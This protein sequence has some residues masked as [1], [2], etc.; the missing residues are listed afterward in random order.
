MASKDRIFIFGLKDMQQI[1]Q[2]KAPNHL[3]RISLS[4]NF[5]DSSMFGSENKQS[6]NAFI[7]FS[8][9]LQR[10]RLKFIDINQPAKLCSL[11]QMVSPNEKQDST[12]GSNSNIAILS[13]ESKREKGIIDVNKNFAVKQLKFNIQGSLLA[14]VESQINQIKIISAPSGEKIC[15]L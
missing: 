14:V 8:E 15:T 11:Q 13:Q 3:L 12:T 9:E 2:F 5:V 10:G 1:A 4:P 6:E 7:A